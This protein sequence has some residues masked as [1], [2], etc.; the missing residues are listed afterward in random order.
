MLFVANIKFCGNP[1]F[2]LN[3]GLPAYLKPQRATYPSLKN[4]YNTNNTLM[5]SRKECYWVMLFPIEVIWV[6]STIK[7]S[8]PFTFDRFLWLNRENNHS[9]YILQSA[10]A[11]YASLIL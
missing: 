10:E 11:P 8:I 5:V 3:V 1:R 4:F 2:K 7:Y 9:I 6:G